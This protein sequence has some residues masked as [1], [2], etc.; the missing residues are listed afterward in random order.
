MTPLSEV[1]KRSVVRSLI[2]PWVTQAI[3]SCPLIVST[4]RRPFL[5]I[6]GTSEIGMV[7]CGGAPGARVSVRYQ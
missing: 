7:V 6:Y 3:M 2:S 4:T 5:W 1:P